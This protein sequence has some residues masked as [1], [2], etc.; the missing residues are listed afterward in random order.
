MQ[1]TIEEPEKP[2]IGAP[3]TS[4]PPGGISVQGVPKGPEPAKHDDS[5]KREEVVPAHGETEINAKPAGEVAAAEE[6]QEEPAATGKRAAWPFYNSDEWQLMFGTI[7]IGMIGGLIA[8]VLSLPTVEAVGYLAAILYGGIAALIAVF[9]LAGTDTDKRIH[10]TIFA[11]LCGFVG[12]PL[13]QKAVS[14]F[15]EGFGVSASLKMSQD[16]KNITTTLLR[17]SP[18][19]GLSDKAADK[20]AEVGN[21]VTAALQAP[22]VKQAPEVQ[23]EVLTNVAN[24][25]DALQA[26]APKAPTETA[27][28]LQ[29]IGVT[30]VQ[31]GKRAIAE[32]ALNVA[33]DL[34]TRPD[35]S[36]SASKAVEV[37]SRILNVKPRLSLEVTR[38]L[39]EVEVERI[40]TA[41]ENIGYP[42][43][44]V[45][46]NASVPA[47]RAR[48]RYYDAAD[49]VEA[50]A[51]RDS[52]KDLASPDAEVVADLQASKLSSIG[53]R[54]F[55]IEVGAGVLTPQ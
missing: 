40:K 26:I 53:P 25:V 44:Q 46:R 7:G 41:L 37:L 20:V 35:T 51:I 55:D 43:S 34:T 8:K 14:N 49:Q 33:R 42:V 48:I 1:T 3:K 28:T 50:E 31:Q 4:P 24:I 15:G 27:K 38:D 29:A 18:D 19:L 45:S 6:K 22:R 13:V 21:K 47:K 2:A 17:D 9:F 32:R 16:A 52:F 5:F 54:H 12:S 30:A 36:P 39:P 10:L 11:L 23:D